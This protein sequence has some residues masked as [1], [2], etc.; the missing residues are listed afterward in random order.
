MIVYCPGHGLDPAL[1]EG[2]HS[3][4]L[5]SCTDKRIAESRGKE[6][7]EWSVCSAGEGDITAVVVSL[8]SP[9]TDRAA[10]VMC[11][12]T[13]SVSATETGSSP[14]SSVKYGAGA[15]WVIGYP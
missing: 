1:T 7:L 5:S 10:Q 3:A 6:S 14:P 12:E 11:F 2:F 8:A 9:S 15:H 4:V 13:P